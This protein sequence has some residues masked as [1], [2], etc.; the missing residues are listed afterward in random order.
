MFEEIWEEITDCI[1]NISKGRGLVIGIIIIVL[2]VVPLFFFK[3]VYKRILNSW[4]DALFYLRIIFSYY[5]LIY[6]LICYYN[7]IHNENRRE[8]HID[9]RFEPLDIIVGNN[10][11]GV[12]VVNHGGGGAADTQN[13]HDSGVQNHIV[14]AV[15]K[16]QEKV[17][18]PQINA[19]DSV[20]Q[21]K[22][23]ILSDYPGSNLHKERAIIAL[24]RM[25]KV[26]GTVARLNLN[27][28]AI[29]QLVWNRILDPVNKEVA[30]TIKE[31]LVEQLSDVMITDDSIYCLQ[32]RVSRMVQALE[33]S[34]KEDIVNVKSIK[35][36][37]QQIAADFSKYREK[38]INRLPD[39]EKKV[40]NEALE[41]NS[42]EQKI[43]AK[44]NLDLKEGLTK[45]LQK[46]YVELG[47]LT[48]Q[49]FNKITTPYF[50]EMMN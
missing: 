11:F 32:G 48:A 17:K 13:V 18:N 20:K 8:I 14:K 43:I 10:P 15:K 40:Y 39:A 38:Y 37:E 2:S 1:Y 6:T 50:K 24:N 25:K 29:L 47:L 5:T 22:D 28:L 30:N 7:N 16:L 3:R 44:I 36:M 49:Q 21:L 26:N 31:N 46:Q 27:E 19:V 45:K 42:E 41:P 4:S 23:Y 9:F 34:D 35:L 12:P 33:L